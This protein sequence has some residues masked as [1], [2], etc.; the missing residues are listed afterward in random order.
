MNSLVLAS[1]SSIRAHLLHNAGLQ[2]DIDSPRVDEQTIKESL[3]AERAKPRDIADA[4]AEAKAQKIANRHPQAMVLGCDQVLDLEGVIFSK[5]SNRNDAEA[6]L[7][8]LRGKTHSLFSAAVL[9]QDS[10]PIWRHVGVARLTMRPISDG[11]LA[12]YLD[13]NWPKVESSVGAYRLEEEGVRLFAQVQG[14]HFT[15]LG[16]PLLELLN[17]LSIR[18]DIPA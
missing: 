9:Y 5:P 4:L 18:G 7:K 12:D 17:F 16:L 10:Q 8:A 11:Y 1:G 3:L 2:F 6:Q 14:S 13:R 15:V